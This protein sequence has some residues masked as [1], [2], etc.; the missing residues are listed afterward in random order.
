MKSKKKEKVGKKY[1]FQTSIN[2]RNL[3][4]HGGRKNTI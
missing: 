2:A 4:F 1:I 3:D